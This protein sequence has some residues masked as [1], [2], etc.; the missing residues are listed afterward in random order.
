[1]STV[2]LFHRIASRSNQR[3]LRSKV[4]TSASDL[5]YA[6]LYTP[7]DHILDHTPEETPLLRLPPLLSDTYG[8]LP[9]VYETTTRVESP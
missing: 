7:H 2:R 5:L 9:L 3:S 8:A 4:K 6:L 1:M